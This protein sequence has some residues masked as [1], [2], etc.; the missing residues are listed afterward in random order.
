[1]VFH[2]NGDVNVEMKDPGPF[3]SMLMF[4]SGKDADH[5]AHGL[6]YT[7]QSQPWLSLLLQDTEG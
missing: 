6:H 1:M 2:S 7:I 3:V 5:E 4:Q